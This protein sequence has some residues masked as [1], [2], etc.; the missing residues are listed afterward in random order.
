[1]LP[2]SGRYSAPAGRPSR[3]CEMGVAG[4]YTIRRINGTVLVSFFCSEHVEPS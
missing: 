1:M 2:Y 4:K 3:G